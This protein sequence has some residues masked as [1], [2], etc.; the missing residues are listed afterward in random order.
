MTR[1]RRHITEDFEIINEKLRANT[2]DTNFLIR[3][4]EKAHEAVRER[5]KKRDIAN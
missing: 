5:K 2:S 4:R 3:I 1:K